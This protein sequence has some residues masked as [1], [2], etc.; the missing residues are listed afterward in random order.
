MTI[1]LHTCGGTFLHGPHPCWQ[2]MHALDE[3][4]I[5]YEQVKHPTFPRG[6][7]DELERLSG[8]RRL[9][10]VEFED[11]TILREDSRALVE[12]IR[13]RRLDEARGA[14]PG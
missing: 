10:V 8:Q 13:E 11:G 7:R 9:P 12:R 5:P 6:R 2:V 4:A 3:A 1:R 14:Q